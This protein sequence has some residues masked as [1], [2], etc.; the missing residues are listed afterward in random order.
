MAADEGSA[1]VLCPPYKRILPESHSLGMRQQQLKILLG[2]V[3]CAVKILYHLV[4]KLQV[5]GS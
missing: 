1:L 5:L 3:L 2:Y 4:H